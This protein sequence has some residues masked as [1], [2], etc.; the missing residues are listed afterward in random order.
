MAL[1]RKKQPVTGPGG[2]PMPAG[3]SMLDGLRLA[4]QLYADPHTRAAM[5]AMGGTDATGGMSTEAMAAAMTWADHV[6]A[7]IQPPAPGYVKRCSCP[8]CG[9]PKKLASVTAYVYCDYCGFLID[10]DMRRAGEH[11]ATPDMSYASLVNG[12]QPQIRAAQAAGDRDGYLGLQH[13]LYDAYVASVPHAVSH[14]ARGDLGY[15]QRLVDYLAAAAVVSAFEPEAVALTEEMKQRAIGL[16]YTSMMP[17]A[18]D[19]AS[20]WPMCETLSRQIEAVNRLNHEH[21][22]N[23]LNPDNTAHLDT[24]LACSSFCQAWLAYLPAD[25]AGQLI[26]WAGLTNTYVTIDVEGGEPRSCGGCGGTLHK[27][28]GATVVVCDGCGRQLDVGAAEIPCTSCGA[29]MTLPPG[30][31]DA[32][33][34]FCRALVRRV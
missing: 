7:L 6:L 20:F 26:E 9:A 14:R 16:R 10:F 23:D 5:T 12:L 1:F 33:C 30:A 34:P 15:R 25:S 21:G 17:M 24:K 28:P 2:Q 18:I 22:V 19:P 8:N 32:T 29:T 11:T 31:T 3:P 4:H 13:Q 27:L